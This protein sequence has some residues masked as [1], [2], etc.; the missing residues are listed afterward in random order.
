MR[1]KRRDWHALLALDNLIIAREL[2]SVVLVRREIGA[3]QI[4]GILD[5]KRKRRDFVTRKK[6]ILLVAFLR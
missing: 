4:S 2:V 5:E 6:R 1:Q 3:M